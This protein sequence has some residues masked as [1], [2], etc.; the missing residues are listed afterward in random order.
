M[1]GHV[2]CR[3]D[4][5]FEIVFD[6]LK[7]RFPAPL[8]LNSGMWTILALVFNFCSLHPSLQRFTPDKFPP[9][10]LN[11]RHWGR[12]FHLAREEVLNVRF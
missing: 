9:A 4:C 6:A 11:E 7:N 12:A 5:L 10:G 3:E 1:R 8:M 2:F